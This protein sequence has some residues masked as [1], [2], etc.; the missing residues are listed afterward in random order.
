MTGAAPWTSITL[1]EVAPTA[2]EAFVAEWERAGANGTLHR[3]LR[4][5]IAFRFVEIA[6]SGA[7]AAQ[8]GLFEI[9]HDEGDVDGPGGTTLISPAEVPAEEDDRFLAGWNRARD[10]LAGQRGNLGTRLHRSVDAAAAFRFVKV[11]RW[12]SPLMF[13]R[14]T[15]RTDFLT[16]PPMPFRM[17]P[18]LYQVV[19]GT[20]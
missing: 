12:S 13:Q 6:R 19:R 14:A 2:D 15:Q 16:L 1:F 10:A 17:H 18:A 5:D 8:P 9:V 7:E 4:G 11:A 20:P 3:A